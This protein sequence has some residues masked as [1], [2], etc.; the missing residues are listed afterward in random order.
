M[1]TKE[2][3]R[4]ELIEI[5]KGAVADVLTERQDLIEDAVCEAILD[6]KLGLA[7]EEADKGEYVSEEE[8]LGKLKA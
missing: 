4:N 7:M 6:M 5:M 8:V 3:S 1:Q 2:I